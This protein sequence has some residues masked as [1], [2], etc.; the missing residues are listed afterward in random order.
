MSG[1]YSRKTF[2][3]KKHYSAVQM[4][5]GRVML[6]SDWNEQSE[7]LQYRDQTESKDVIGPSGVP[8]DEN[9]FEITFS[10]GGNDLIIE[11]GKIYAEGLLCE[12]EPGKT[13]VSYFN[14][15]HY[16]NPD[17]TYFL[18]SPPASP[19]ESPPESP[20]SSPPSEGIAAE[21]QNGTYLVYLDAWQQ[22][23]NHLDD[24]RIKE[25]ALGQA[26]TTTRLKVVWQVKMLPVETEPGEEVSCDMDLDKWQD[27]ISPPSGKLNA[28]TVEKGS[29]TEPCSLPPSAGYQRLENQLYRIEIHKGGDRNEATYKWSRDNASVQTK[30]T[31]VDGKVLTVADLGKDEILGFAA[32]QWVEIID[33]EVALNNKTTSLFQIDSVTPETSEITLDDSAAAFQGKK[34]L[35]LVR[36]DQNGT[37]GDADGIAMASGWQEIEGGIE[38]QFSNGSYRDGDYWLIPARTAT[39][40]IE[41]PPFEIPNLNPEEQ[42]PRGVQH[43]FAKLAMLHV[44]GG[45]GHII[46]CR[47]KFP[48]LTNLK[49]EDIG[50]DSGY[51]EIGDATT[52]QD[53]I[54][55]LCDVQDLRDHNKYVHGTGVVCGLKVICAPDRANVLV[56]KGYAIDC[57]GNAIHVRKSYDKPYGIVDEA[58]EKQLLD[59][60]GNCE[61]SLYLTGASKKG[62]HLSI[63]PYEEK[64]FWDIVLEGTL[65]KNF[66]DGCIQNLIDFLK[67]N[68]PLKF[69]DKAPVPLSQRRLTALIN[70]LAQL[71]NSRSGPYAFLSGQ[72]IKDRDEIDCKDKEAIGQYEDQILWCLYKELKELL[73]SQTYCAM[74]DGDT[75]FPKYEIDPGL[76]TIF[77]TVGRFHDKV[78]LHPSGK[79][80]YTSGLDNRLYVYDLEKK[81]M[82]QVLH[83]PSSSNVIIQDFVIHPSGDNLYAVGSL[84]ETDC[85]F[86]V[87]DIGGDGEVTWGKTSVKCEEQFRSL[88][89][90]VDG[91]I[92]ATQAGNG[93]YEVKGIGQNNFSVSQLSSFN[94]TGMLIV[95]GQGNFAYA[96]QN[97][98][99]DGVTDAF[100]EIS[101]YP[102]DGGESDRTFPFNGSDQ[103]DD[104]ALH[105]DIL[106]IT[107]HKESD[108]SDHILGG[109]NIS[110]GNSA[111][112][113]INLEDSWMKRI[114]PVDAGEFGQYLLITL[115][116]KFKV[117]RINLEQH[118]L[119]KRFRIPTQLFPMGIATY[120][121]P[122]SRERKTK[123]YVVNTIVNTITDID[124]RVAFD[125]VNRPNF[126]HEPP[127]MLASYRE[128]VI[129]AYSDLFS[130]FLQYLKDCFTDKFLVD[131]PECNENDKV[132]LATVDIRNNR[133]YHIN[134]FSKR[135]YVKSPELWEYWLSTV[136]ILPVFK[137]A[138]KK[139]AGNIL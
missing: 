132:Y 2:D 44:E 119:D 110:D 25:V 18:S 127:S 107:G 48:P 122:E 1:D 136:P 100:T 55:M 35:K 94:A 106:Y 121:I 108:A 66:Y 45:E 36:W 9:G 112:E 5:Q 8:K 64:D 24:P 91:R 56:E 109:F 49:A 74:F 15:P 14:Q 50:Y 57:E 90:S 47:R 120:S 53:A 37:T 102:L 42:P 103:R 39:G 33:E 117:I 86:A 54:D 68:F 115:A 7:I 27:H 29:K 126:V 52:V 22:E 93:L 133:V 13:P 58:R 23:I 19:P 62:P 101:R 11:P 87:A 69:E 6:D 51:C 46:D 84:D 41:W 134:N 71:V 16:P 78:K 75:P 4:Q 12:L 123:A 85:V 76:E 77:G 79:Y 99:A 80:A 65:I 82:I 113:A 139:F 128:G 32:G 20:P 60:T 137:E 73:D 61:V 124:L 34:K 114:S 31:E 88:A 89:I 92:F 116:D 96:A 43:H 129:E 70:L 118:Y 26:D 130:H 59:E 17:D 28:R 104:I 21:I 10:S 67:K 83:F 30:I 97:P 38:V 111:F 3:K 63:E 40:E 72:I 131:C 98:T 138:F 135:E 105:N 81:E 125:E 95:P